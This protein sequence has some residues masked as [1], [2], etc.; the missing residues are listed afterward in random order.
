VPPELVLVSP[1]EVCPPSEL[2]ANTSFSLGT[3]N[4]QPA[5]ML[6]LINARQAGAREI[7]WFMVCLDSE[8]E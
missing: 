8:L 6:Q 1:P 3:C 5:M 7:G 4:E 2:F